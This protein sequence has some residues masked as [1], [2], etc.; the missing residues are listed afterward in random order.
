MGGFFEHPEACPG[1]PSAP[2]HCGNAP[3][4]R[5]C[6]G[7]PSPHHPHP[8]HGGRKGGLLGGAGVATSPADARFMSRGHPG[9]SSPRQPDDSRNV[10]RLPSRIPKAGLK[11]SLPPLPQP[12]NSQY[13]TE[14]VIVCVTRALT[15]PPRTRL[16]AIPTVVH[17]RMVVVHV[18]MVVVHVRM[19]AAYAGEIENRS[20]LQFPFSLDYV[21]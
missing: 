12:T 13:S 19:V 15:L 18:R 11:R 9:R 7:R 8:D 10:Q 4:L 1:C 6:E 20:N 14:K 3:A 21:L 2:R 5:A 17:V 16:E